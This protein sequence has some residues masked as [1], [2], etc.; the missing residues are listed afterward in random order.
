MFEPQLS[1]LHV[2]VAQMLLIMPYNQVLSKLDEF[3]M[4]CLR[5]WLLHMCE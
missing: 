5:I 4:P 3:E 2:L 1:V